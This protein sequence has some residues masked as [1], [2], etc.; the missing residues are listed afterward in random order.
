CPVWISEGGETTPRFL[1]S[2]KLVVDEGSAAKLLL[3]RAVADASQLPGL[4]TVIARIVVERI[5]VS[6]R[7]IRITRCYLFHCLSSQQSCLRIV[8]VCLFFEAS[9]IERLHLARCVVNRG[10]SE[11][12]SSE[13]H[14]V[15]P[16]GD[17]I[18]RFHLFGDA[19]NAVLNR[20]VK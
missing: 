10:G 9:D 2:S 13:L 12:R 3:D 7:E 16:A 8:G 14:T 17:I 4:R 6:Q 11:R 5:V 18:G 20:I 19:G 15:E 1:Q